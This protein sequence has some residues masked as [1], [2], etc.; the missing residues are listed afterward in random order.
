MFFFSETSLTQSW[1][2][3]CRLIKF[4]TTIAMT[5][6]RARQYE[7]KMWQKP[8][9]AFCERSILPIPSCWI[10][11]DIVKQFVLSFCHFSPTFGNPKA[12]LLS[13]H[14]LYSSLTEWNCEHN[15]LNPPRTL[16]YLMFFFEVWWTIAQKLLVSH[17]LYSN[18][19]AW[20]Q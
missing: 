14:I 5:H 1:K 12:Q 7:G 19:D 16:E 9:V 18:R 17:I 4:C 20:L 2:H 11:L 3:S 13:Q 8:S 15:T 6:W 10:H